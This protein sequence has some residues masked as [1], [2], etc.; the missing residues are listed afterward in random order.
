MPHLEKVG[1]G[2]VGQMPRLI[3]PHHHLY[4]GV[5]GLGTACRTL[6]RTLGQA[7]LDAGRRKQARAAGEPNK[8]SFA[9]NQQQITRSEQPTGL[10]PVALCDRMLRK[11]WVNLTN[12]QSCVTRWERRGNRLGC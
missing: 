8:K 3:P 2:K 10:A 5:G 7:G 6:C 11:I 12:N 4:R 9:P 1:R